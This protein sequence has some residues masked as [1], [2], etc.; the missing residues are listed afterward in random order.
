MKTQ[1]LWLIVALVAASFAGGALVTV[2][3]ERAG[4]QDAKPRMTTDIVQAEA[5]IITDRGGA[6]RAVLNASPDGIVALT[7]RD[8]QGRERIRLST[9]A[10][11]ESDVAVLADDGS[12]RVR[13]NPAGLQLRDAN[14]RPR[15]WLRLDRDGSPSLVLLDDQSIGRAVLG[16]A[17]FADGDTRPESSLVLLS[18]SQRTVF[19]AP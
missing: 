8:A 5:F 2:A 1:P 4:A 14:G 15:A 11:G 7:L 17:R 9:S 6:A 12:Y 16:A 10:D 13:L 3:Q 19:A 18:E